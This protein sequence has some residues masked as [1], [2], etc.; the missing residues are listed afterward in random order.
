M[1]HSRSRPASTRGRGPG[2]GPEVDHRRNHPH[3]RRAAADAE[4]RPRR[5]DSAR[6]LFAQSGV[7]H[8]T[9]RDICNAAR[10]NVAAV[11]YHFGD[12]FGLYMEILRGGIALM[13]ETNEMARV[14]GQGKPPEEQLRAYIK[15]F[16]ER[17]AGKDRQSWLQRMMSHEL[18]TPTSALDVVFEQVIQ[19]RLQDV[20]GIVSALLECPQDDPRVLRC[21]GS[22]FGQCQVYQWHHIRDRLMENKPLTPE[23][24]E[25]LAHHVCEFSLAGIRNLAEQSRSAS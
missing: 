2:R 21:V 3:G 10:A 15:V 11:N 18:A 19:P 4:T 25:E 5:L 22:I 13:T 20:G 24:I 12:K 17:V 8:V 23:R 1:F 14:A 6:N 16:L 7:H 9:V